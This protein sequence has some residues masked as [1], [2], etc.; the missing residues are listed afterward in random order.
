[1]FTLPFGVDL[2]VDKF[3]LLDADAPIERKS[4]MPFCFC[5]KNYEPTLNYGLIR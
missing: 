4:L 5:F 3:V 1:V 2:S